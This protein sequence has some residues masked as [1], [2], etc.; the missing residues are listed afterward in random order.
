MGQNVAVERL[1]ELRA[2]NAATHAAGEAAEDG[3]RHGTEGDADRAG[4]S[5]DSCASLTTSEGS[6]DAT[7]NTTDSADSS[8]GFHGVMERS[9]FGGVTARALQ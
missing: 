3:A 8:A 4:E 6:A 9:D 7:S 5:T 2:E 1:T